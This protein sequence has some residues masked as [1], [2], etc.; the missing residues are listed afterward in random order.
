MLVPGKIHG[1]QLAGSI[2]FWLADLSISRDFTGLL[3]LHDWW[4][5]PLFF[6][7]HRQSP[8]TGLM[9]G[10]LP[11]FKGVQWVNCHGIASS[12]IPLSLTS[13]S[14]FYG[15]F[16]YE[17]YKIME[18]KLSRYLILLPVNCHNFFHSCVIAKLVVPRPGWSVHLLLSPWW[19]SCC[20]KLRL[21]D[22][23]EP[24]N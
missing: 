23:Y 9:A 2:L 6:R 18:M 11:D 5:F 1:L 14:A 20:N 3:C 7:G 10:N 15:M 4:K 21:S 19:Y 16:L 22:A 8:C 13:V 24:L 17:K 12:K